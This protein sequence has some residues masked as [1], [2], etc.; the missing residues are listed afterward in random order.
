[1]CFE[2]SMKFITYDR[3]WRRAEMLR[4]RMISSNKP[5]ELISKVSKLSSSF[6]TKSTDFKNMLSDKN[7]I[8][9]KC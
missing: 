2:Y 9:K 3:A 1:M 6:R 5:P 4:E 8:D 7:N